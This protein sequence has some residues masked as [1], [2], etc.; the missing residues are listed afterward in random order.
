MLRPVIAVTTAAFLLGGCT[1]DSIG[2]RQAVGA[3]GG[4]VGGAFLGDNVGKGKGRTLATAAGTLA[5]LAIGSEIGRSLDRANELYEARR[6]G[7]AGHS[8]QTP[9]PGFAPPPRGH[10][11]GFAGPTRNA[12]ASA[13]TIRDAQNCRALDSGGL[14]PAY[15]CRNS[16]GQWFVLQ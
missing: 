11:A 10:G 16:V 12:S 7:S 4:A 1:S 3:L 15:A 5:G 13:P 14:R 2:P 9:V 8:Q 6:Y